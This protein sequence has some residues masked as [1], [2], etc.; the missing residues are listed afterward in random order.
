MSHRCLPAMCGMVA[1]V[2]LTPMLA[3]AQS[4]EVRDRHGRS[5]VLHWPRVGPLYKTCYGRSH[6]SRPVRLLP[7]LVHNS[8]EG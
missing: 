8:I 6:P 4:P 3:A 2:A 1:V 5:R 7:A